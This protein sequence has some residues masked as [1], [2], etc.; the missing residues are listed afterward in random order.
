MPPLR[1]RRMP[2]RLASNPHRFHE[3]RSEI[4]QDL[5]SLA[6]RPL[7][8]ALPTEWVGTPDLGADDFDDVAAEPRCPLVPRIVRQR[9]ATDRQ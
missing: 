7:R 1:G 2:P 3:D 9:A 6:R 8:P 4:A 5:S